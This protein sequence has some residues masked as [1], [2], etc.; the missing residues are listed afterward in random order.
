MNY[1]ELK[2]KLTSSTHSHTRYYRDRD[3]AIYYTFV[4]K[5]MNPGQFNFAAKFHFSVVSALQT[6]AH[7]SK[8]WISITIVICGFM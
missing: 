6:K 7:I 8:R 1:D 5:V 4:Q 3:N 2:I